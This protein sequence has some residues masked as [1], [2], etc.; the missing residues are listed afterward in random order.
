[1]EFYVIISSVITAI[2][3]PLILDLRSGKR[4]DKAI[5]KLSQSLADLESHLQQ[6]EES[7]R[8]TD[9]VIM[10]NE[11]VRALKF[12]I[13]SNTKVIDSY[14]YNRIC[15]VFKRYKDLGLNGEV[16]DMFNRFMDL[17]EVDYSSKHENE[18]YNETIK[19]PK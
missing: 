11:L 13:N 5:A 19:L 15:S 10:H 2:V 18:A 8:D 1:M 16:E 4:H 14:D 3:A 7:S 6:F 12:Y 17:V 9:R